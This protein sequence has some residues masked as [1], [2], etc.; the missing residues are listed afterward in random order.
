MTPPGGGVVALV[1]GVLHRL[2]GLGNLGGG[3]PGPP[4]LFG[5]FEVADLGSATSHPQR[6]IGAQRCA[7]RAV[8]GASQRRPPS[9]PHARDA[10]IF[11]KQHCIADP[12]G[13]Q[14]AELGLASDSPGRR[15]G[16]SSDGLRQ[17]G[18][19]LNRA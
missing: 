2:G 1:R 15:L 4:A 9:H 8:R 13:A 7:S 3:V 11:V 6:R 14:T 5:G 17:R 18:S 12:A 19:R 16:E 10:Q